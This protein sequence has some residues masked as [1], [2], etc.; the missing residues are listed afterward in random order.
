MDKEGGRGMITGGQGGWAWH[1]HRWTRRVGVAWSQVDKEG[2]RG[3]ITG[4]QGGWAWH[5]HRWTR[6]V[7]VA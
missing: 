3:M 6:R 4:G 7:G 5:D 1:D 2:G